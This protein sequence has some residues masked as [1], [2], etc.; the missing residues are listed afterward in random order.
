MI[1][2]NNN[3]ACGTMHFGHY[4]FEVFLPLGCGLE[5]GDRVRW[6]LQDAVTGEMLAKQ[7]AVS[8]VDLW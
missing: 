6:V 7:E 4:A 1:E 5:R 8:Q 2:S 3:P